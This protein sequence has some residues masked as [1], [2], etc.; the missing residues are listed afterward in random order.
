ME[1]NLVFYITKVDGGVVEQQFTIPEDKVEAVIQQLLVQYA[2]V[3]VMKKDG[4]KVT[5]QSD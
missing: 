3:G 5:R 1:T 2:Q 4:N